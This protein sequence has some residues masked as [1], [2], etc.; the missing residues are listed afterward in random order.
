RR[1]QELLAGREVLPGVLELRER[2]LAA[3]LKLAIASSSSRGWVVGHLE[4]LGIGEGWDCIVCR[5]D[6]ELAKPDPGLYLAALRCLGVA[7][8]EAVAIEDS[9]HGVTAARA[10]AVACLV[11]PS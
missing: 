1:T 9:G 3:G 10:A 4:R 8:S 7:A 2:A 5:E 11:V 6:S